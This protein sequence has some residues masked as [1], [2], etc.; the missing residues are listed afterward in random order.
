MKVFGLQ[1]ALYR[2][3]SLASR[4][5]TAPQDATVAGRRHLLARWHTARRQGLSAAQAAAA[6]G[7]SPATLYRWQKRSKPRSRRP[8]RVRANTWRSTPMVTE[9]EALPSI[10]P[11]GASARSL[12]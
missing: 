9:V 12:S 10:I 2:G 3:A 6:V 7:V 4:L 8:R 5:D 11:C 1:A